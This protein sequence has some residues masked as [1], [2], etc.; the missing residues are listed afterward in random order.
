MPY[1]LLKVIVQPVLA[2]DEDGY[3]A[4]NPG[5]PVSIPP[6]DWPGYPERLAAE[7]DRLNESLAGPE[8]EEGGDDEPGA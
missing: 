6:R 5:E 8:P 1:R 4:E 3:L 2:L 7:I